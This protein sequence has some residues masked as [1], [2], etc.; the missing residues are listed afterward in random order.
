LSRNQPIVEP[1]IDGHSATRFK[2]GSL[3]CEH[4]VENRM[5]LLSNKKIAMSTM[6]WTA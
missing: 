3:D 1:F 2:V 4:T 5:N 6:N